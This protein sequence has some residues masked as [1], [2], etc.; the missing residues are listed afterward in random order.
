MNT[1]IIAIAGGTGSGKSHL[2]KSI[3][4]TYPKGEMLIIEQDSYYKDISSLGYEDRC[5]Q[6]FDHP[7]AIDSILIES[8]LEKLISGETINGP[9]YNFFKHLREKN[10]KKIK[11]CPIIIIEG[12]LMLHYVRLHKFYT[13]KVFVETP[14]NIRINRREE[15]DIHFRGRTIASIKK[16]YYS[17]VKPMHEKFVQPSKS[18]SDIVI[19][20]TALIDKSVNQIK[21]KIDLVIK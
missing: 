16:Q 7:D 12:I 18:Y 4:N 14:E 6:N 3:V 15:R 21:S 9:K 1:I 2:A 8:H 20:G 19:E 13:L 5:K 17:T 10:T 11:R